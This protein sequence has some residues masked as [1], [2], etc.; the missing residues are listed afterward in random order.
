[1]LHDGRVKR[2]ALICA[3]YWRNAL[4]DAE[5]GRGSFRN[6][7]VADFVH[8]QSGDLRQGHIGADALA[9][10]FSGKYAEAD[11]RTV[12]LRPVIYRARTLHGRRY[13]TISDVLTPIVSSATLYRDGRL[14]VPAKTVVPRDVLEPLD[15][16]A[17]AIGTVEALDDFLT[18]HPGPGIALEEKEGEG[19]PPV[20]WDA[21][22]RYCEKLAQAVF[23][24]LAGDDR[25]EL[26]DGGFIEAR[27]Q[28][29]SGRAIRALYDHIEEEQPDAPLFAT[30]AAQPL[31]ETE[32]CLPPATGFAARLGHSSPL[33]ALA[34]AQRSALSHLVVAEHGEVV[35]VN[36]PPG[37]GK[38]TLLL[39]VVA[40]LWA[41]AALDEG[42][43]PII[44]ASSTNNQAVTNI[45]D[46]FGADF[47]SGE[48]PFAGRWLPDVGSF[49]SYFPAAR[50]KKDVADRY[51]TQD[52][53]NRVEDA[54]YLDRAEAAFLDAAAAAFP[55]L[56][57]MRVETVV[58]ALHGRLRAQ[59]DALARIEAAWEALAAAR[60]RGRAILGDDPAIVQAQRRAAVEAAE[61]AGRQ[62][63]ALRA[64][65][66]HHQATES[67]F[68]VL[69]GWLPPVAGKRL[70]GARIALRPLWPEPLPDWRHVREIGPAM[71]RIAEAARLRIAACRASLAEADA[72]RESER[73]CLDRWRAAV[74]ELGIAAADAGDLTL[75]ACDPLADRHLRFPIFL[76][77]THYWEGRWL[78]DMASI[79]NLAGEKRR[80]GRTSVVPRWRRRMMLTPCA[81]STFYVLPDL[82]CVRRR[83]GEDYVD[84]YLYDTIDL[85]IVDEAGQVP[86][87]V[88][89]AA[90]ALARCA[91]V[92]GDTAQI[93]PIWN[94]PGRVD[95]GNLRDA[96]ILATG[97][98]R[99]DRNAFVESGRAAASGSVM[100]V[101]QTVSRYHQEPDLARGLMLTEHRRCFDEIIGYCNDLCYH[102]KLKPLRGRKADAVGAGADGLPALGYL[103]VDG[104]CEQLRGGSRRNLAEAETIAAWVAGRK[105]ALEQ[106][107]PGLTLAQILGI[108]APF[109]AQAEAIRAAL[110]KAGIDMGKGRAVLVGSVHSF[111]GGQRPV[112][113]FSPTYSKHADGE[114]IDRSTSMLNVAVSRA[115][116]SFLVFGD[117]DCFS[118]TPRGS[119]RGLLA[120]RLFASDGNALDF[121]QVPRRDL[122]RHGRVEHLR[123]AAEHDAFLRDVLERCRHAAQV[124][125]PWLSQ[126]ALEESG[127]LPLLS[128]A[129]G[130][131]IELTVYT[132]RLLNT[133][134]A[135]EAG[136]QDELARAR[137]ML[138]GLGIVLVDVRDVHSKIVMA[139]DDLFCAGSFN[140][141]SA[142]RDG[143]YARHETSLVY[144]GAAVAKEIE[145]MKTSLAKRAVR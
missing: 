122:V 78:L 16:N 86:P 50:K 145:A 136:V 30:F 26:A 36:G 39:S 131:G 126:R 89:G 38:T 140:W 98:E 42:E 21:Y 56:E 29:G 9:V 121:A 8:V 1:M 27:D 23:P 71:D 128:A 61:A 11:S 91:L 95:R 96:G 90:F 104:L 45:I 43:P 109:A 129:V 134:R 92:I 82:L 12:L 62:A 85:L 54:D 84:D 139:D 25:F 17:H 48:G 114:F 35:A 100:R 77:A 88:G 105:A 144:R 75:A 120:A 66:D 52:F 101:A 79:E 67:L 124:V 94:I 115:M 63:Q 141:F 106:S 59:A 64:A 55:D 132:D 135:R 68:L 74:A 37:T 108:V 10:L 123:D 65:W 20:D 99:T 69:F 76:T 142:A 2:D 44:L 116:N 138:Q 107:Y 6:E 112:M 70:A 4:A 81:V 18:L 103:Q 113:I 130:R 117:M 110:G 119:P 133:K 57:D 13:T 72:L 24:E 40:S 97:E 28:A 93:E 22:R 118:A 87:E 5:L 19:P 32:P 46:A 58:K 53:F 33:Y 80:K 49:G 111:Q 60:E 102:G 14:S 41:K 137:G 127:L 31:S 15:R 73:A 3:R 51:L 7:D 47:A 125:T 83:D 34:E 143:I